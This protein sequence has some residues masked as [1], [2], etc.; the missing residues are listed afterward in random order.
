MGTA[1]G[2]ELAAAVSN[3]GGLGVIGG[4]GF[5]PEM[6]RK[7]LRKLKED[8]IDKS[9]PFGVDLLIPQVGGNA[10][11]TNYDYV[12]YFSCS[13]ALHVNGRP[14]FDMLVLVHTNGVL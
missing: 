2:S 7:N 9:L 11:A 1:A 5:S 13:P 8:L 14:P 3:A 12:S 6:L 10:R 4:I